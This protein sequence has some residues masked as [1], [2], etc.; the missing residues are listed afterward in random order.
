MGKL[1]RRKI[2]VME[3]RTSKIGQMAVKNRGR[4]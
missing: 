2:E 3:K 1:V 4:G